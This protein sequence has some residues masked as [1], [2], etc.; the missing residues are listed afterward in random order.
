[1]TLIAHL[2]ELRNRL[3]KVVLAVAI[4]A[5]VGFV[6]Y[7]WIFDILIEPYQQLCE[8]GIGQT[9]DDN[10]RLLVTNPLEGFSVRIKVST[11]AGVALAMPVILWQI[12]R[13][14]TPGLYAH[15]KR[16]AMP[17]VTSAMMLFIAG[18]GIAYW[19]MPKALQF[20]TEIGGE[21]L[22]NAFSPASYFHLIVYMMLAFGVGFE[23]PIVLIFLQMAGVV[24]TATLR[25]FRRY[26][27]VGIAVMVAI[28]TPSGDP[29]SMLALTIPMVLFYE[30]A[31]VVGRVMERRRATT[32]AAPA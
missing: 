9:L 4:G 6:A 17:F 1:M 19:T 24:T 2:T 10:C 14:V 30:M 23:F 26:A 18:A 31:I 29:I 32:V 13:F 21:N 28:A 3:I 5:V 11:Y 20:L 25:R 16:Y 15:E 8:A 27:I 12:W 7:E 22:V